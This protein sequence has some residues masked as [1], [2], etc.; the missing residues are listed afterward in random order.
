M[1]NII[2][3]NAVL[4]HDQLG[5]LGGGDRAEGRNTEITIIES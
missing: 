3:I 2:L 1:M 5:H 4:K